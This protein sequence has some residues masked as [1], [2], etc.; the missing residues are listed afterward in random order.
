MEIDSKFTIADLNVKC[1]NKTELYNLLVNEV[2]NFFH[3]PK[4]TCNSL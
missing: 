2:K 1:I 3:I 4:I